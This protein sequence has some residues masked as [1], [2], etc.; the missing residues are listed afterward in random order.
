MEYEECVPNIQVYKQ[1]NN[2]SLKH[3]YVIKELCEIL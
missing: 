3:Q 1:H 2:F